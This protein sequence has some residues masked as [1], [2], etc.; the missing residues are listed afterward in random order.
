MTNIYI[1]GPLEPTKATICIPEIAEIVQSFDATPMWGEAPV[2]EADGVIV[3]LS[4]KQE[5]LFRVL[6]AAKQHEKRT[7][8]TM[9]WSS[10]SELPE[11]FMGMT[12][13]RPDGVR[14]LHRDYGLLA[15]KVFMGAHYRK[16]IAP[17]L[18]D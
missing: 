2:E 3:D 15:V 12:A 13:M 11:E 16:S 8:I 4:E 10:Q 6:H 5:A 18:E 17:D 1:A 7:L 9:A 14:Y